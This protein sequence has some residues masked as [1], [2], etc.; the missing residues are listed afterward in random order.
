VWAAIG[1]IFFVWSLGSHLNAFG[2]NTGMI[3]PGAVLRYVPIVSNARIPGRAIVVAYLA[4]SVL[5]AIG[6][7]TWRPRRWRQWTWI[8]ACAA[9]VVIDFLPSPFPTVA[10]DR[11]AIY[12]ALRNRPERGSVCE[13]PLGIHDGFG[14]RG[15]TDDRTMFYQSIHERPVTGGYISR[16]PPLVSSTYAQ[17]PLLN[18][19][20]DL[21]EEKPGRAAGTL[22]LPDAETAGARLRANGI[23]FVVLNRRL[24]P[25]AL[26]Q[27]V[28]SV[29][30]LELI[31]EDNERAL[32]AVKGR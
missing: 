3:L 27:Y 24:A 31:A 8:A 23:A 2:F 28:E 10:L 26:T 12:E 21:S 14:G 19:L 13:L 32:Y 7:A 16:L 30:Q 1:A 9:A 17:D 22:A 6:A 5:A 4:L 15:F 18:A 25:A 11:P 29:L 20:L